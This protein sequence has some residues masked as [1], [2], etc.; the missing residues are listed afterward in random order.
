MG[1]SGSKEHLDDAVMGLHHFEL[2][3]TIG[4]GAFGKVEIVRKITSDQ[5]Y[6]LKYIDKAKCIKNK[7]VE[8]IIHE[9]DILEE[10]NHTFV[11]NLHYAFQDE[12][13]L[14]MVLD[15]MLG[16]DLRYLLQQSEEGI[17]EE[18]VRF[19]IAELSLA[20]EYLHDRKIAHRDI[21]PD[22]IMISEEGHVHLTDFNLAARV[23]P[24]E[25]STEVCGT[26]YYMAPEMVSRHKYWYTVDWWSLGVVM[27]ELLM[28][29]VP[30]TGNNY[31]ELAQ[32][33]AL[34]TSLQLS[35]PISEECVSILKG[36]LQVNPEYRLGV[37]VRGPV[38]GI[39]SIKTHPFMEGMD[40]E[41]LANKQVEPPFVPQEGR[42]YFDPTFELEEML[43]EDNPLHKNGKGGKFHPPEGDPFFNF[44]AF[45]KD[46]PQ[47]VAIR[48]L[49]RTMPLKEAQEF[50]EKMHKMNMLNDTTFQ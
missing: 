9:R 12:N 43:L 25:P 8:N 42:L 16:G 50:K 31:K 29:T 37:C 1:G 13:F 21:K 33:I 7:A 23:S 28:G 5:L 19:Y 24:E 4:R 10:L 35:R 41:K 11:V 38:T 18:T 14:Y 26:L 44:H 3:R 45:N 34:A 36:L 17:S 20:L 27:W 39:D 49:A 32:N 47:I 2:L 40:W 30:F 48:D 22:N 6:A 15:L 46:D